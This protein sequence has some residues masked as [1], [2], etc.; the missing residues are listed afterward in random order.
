MNKRSKCHFCTRDLSDSHFVMWVD[1]DS[2]HFG[3][4]PPADH[5]LM[6][7]P[8]H[9]CVKC[10][11]I[12]TAIADVKSEF[13]GRI[14]PFVRTRGYVAR[15]FDRGF[16]WFEDP[17]QF[18]ELVIEIYEPGQV[19]R[20]WTFAFIHDEYVVEITDGAT[21]FRV[22]ADEWLRGPVYAATPFV[23][24][25]IAS[26]AAAMLQVLQKEELDEQLAA[27]W[28]HLYSR[29]DEQDAGKRERSD[30]FLDACWSRGA[31]TDSEVERYRQAWAEEKS[32]K[33]WTESSGERVGNQR[34]PRMRRSNVR[35][36]PTDGVKNASDRRRRRTQD[37]VK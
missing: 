33:D 35:K 5:Q 6:T 18:S 29:L 25:Q 16:Q 10:H 2:V 26:E 9:V 7:E 3:E 17:D 12:Y 28:D 36:R 30:G 31:L 24:C 22:S 34:P 32:V 27:E 11:D 8:V 15:A 14:P 13:E 1:E 4:P 23:G 19:R 37:E 21:S 20:F